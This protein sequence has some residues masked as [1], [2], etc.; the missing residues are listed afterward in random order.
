MK[1]GTFVSHTFVCVMATIILIPCVFLRDLKVLS[2]QKRLLRDRKK[3]F[4]KFFR[5]MYLLQALLNRLRQTVFRNS[6]R[7]T[8]FSEDY[9]FSPHWAIYGP[10]SKSANKA[11]SRSNFEKRFG[12]IDSGEPGESASRGH[13]IRKKF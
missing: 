5:M 1:G 7:E 6:T 8:L 3:S 10:K 4:R 12:A 13:I 2:G 11:C 9:A